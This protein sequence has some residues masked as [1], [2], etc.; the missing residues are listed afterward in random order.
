MNFIDD[1]PFENL[2]FSSISFKTA[3]YTDCVFTNCQFVGVDLSAC[4]FQDC[5]FENCDLSNAKVFETAFQDVQFKHSKLMGLGFDQCRTFGLAI[6][7]EHCQLNHAIFYQVDLSKCRFTN[8]QMHEADLTEADLSGI[9]LTQCDLTGT[10]FDQTNLQKTDL[11]DSFNFQIDPVTNSITGATFSR[12][13]LEGLLM[14]Y[15]IRVV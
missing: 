15:R 9:L 11:S 4:R 1:Q 2:D 6:S 5:T 13:S 8:C 12:N 14:E 10:T 7:F 3:E